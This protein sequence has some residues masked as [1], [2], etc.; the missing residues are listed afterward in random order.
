MSWSEQ[1]WLVSADEASALL[2]AY[3]DLPIHL[4]SLIRLTPEAASVLS[5][6]NYG[7]VMDGLTDMHPEVAVALKPHCWGLQVRGLTR[8]S[9]EL[10][11]A[12]AEHVGSLTLDVS[13]L[14]HIES[15]MLAARLAK[16][17]K[18]WPS[19]PSLLSLSPEVADALFAECPP[20]K[21]RGVSLDGL[22][23]ITAD[24]AR[25]LCRQG[26]DWLS[27][28]SLHVLTIDSATVLAT[29]SIR[30][31]S[32]SGIP[33]GNCVLAMG[34][35]E[36]LA[37]SSN[38]LEVGGEAGVATLFRQSWHPAFLRKA[39]DSL[40]DRYGGD[41]CLDLDDLTSLSIDQ[42]K[43]LSEINV[44]S[45]VRLRSI[46]ELPEDTIDVL[47]GCAGDVFLDLDRLTNSRLARKLRDQDQEHYEGEPAVYNC[48]EL[49]AGAAKAI[50]SHGLPLSFPKLSQLLPDVAHALSMAAQLHLDGV[51]TLSFEAA[52]AIA[53][54]R[55]DLHL[56]GLEAISAR[57]AHSLAKHET[58]LQ[59]NGITAL[60]HDSACALA[61][62]CPEAEPL[63]LNGLKNAPPEA[64]TALRSCPSIVLPVHEE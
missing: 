10:G 9:R 21:D 2:Q 1:M 39:V 56:N 53:K 16:E 34:A 54:H 33:S 63:S 14:S 50:V 22:N 43:A 29:S 12:L 6:H 20:G 52:A 24:T 4:P 31:L 28:N 58:S 8:I 37:R 15:P 57:I 40:N 18:W 26:L 45:T 48:Q 38:K 42:A 49:G 60:S 51:T 30:D 35:E 11:D 64:W 3:R 25:V 47:A 32:L 23:T 7:L 55:D 46:K 17:A 5:T 61:T 13:R 27:L 41:F 36:I 44:C 62:R 19:F 59:M